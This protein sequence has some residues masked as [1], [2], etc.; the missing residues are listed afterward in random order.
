MHHVLS[1]S[2]PSERS[3]PMK[4]TQQLSRSMKWPLA[5]LGYFT[6]I[7]ATL[8]GS[9][10]AFPANFQQAEIKAAITKIKS[11]DYDIKAAKGSAG[12][13]ARPA[14][15]GRKKLTQSRLD[16]A[17]KKLA[18]AEKIMANIPADSSDLGDGRK[19]LAASKKAIAQIEAIINGGNS[20]SSTP[21]SGS[22][23]PATT[24]N[25]KQPTTTNKPVVKKLDYKQEKL[26]K[27]ARWY[28]LETEKYTKPASDVVKRMDAAGPKPLHKDV[29]AA[30]NSINTGIPK[31]NLAVG[32]I[33]KLPAAHPDVA[34]LR[35]KIQA[36][37]DLLGALQSRL[38][39]E[40]AKLQK[41]TGLEN[42]PNY[43][44]DYELVNGLARRYGNFSMSAEQPESFAQI[45]TEDGQSL[46]EF[47]RIAKIYQPLAEQKTDAGIKMEKRVIYAL[48][49]RKEFA[50]RLTEY[51]KKLPS[52]FAADI[53]EAEKLATQGVNEKKPMFFGENSG[54][55]QRF[56]WAEKKL[57]VIR[58]FGEKQAKPYVEQL[59]AARERIAKQAKSLEAEIIAN[60][61][62]PANR[63]TGPKRDALIKLAQETWNAEEK[64]AKYLAACIPSEA[65]NRD[66]R[67]RW[68][69]GSFYKIDSS[70]IQVQLIV[71]Y[72]DKL[73]VIRPV[74][75][76]KN[77]M[78]GDTITASPFHSKDEKL[79]PRNFIILDKV[80]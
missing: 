64:G 57:I 35:T 33:G 29:T 42:Y 10:K 16:S 56:G 8:L 24:G 30:L 39:V 4:N 38:K 28:L 69:S 25:P 53:A 72:N 20:G 52:S 40:S 66:T 15:G 11:A 67:W 1:A 43:Q 36:A 48:G 58:A 46:K 60:N 55:Q 3:S 7:A 41:I 32:Y 23:P 73:A 22:T 61:A 78:L 37:G 74:N 9:P 70:K 62:M 2:N 27:D 34:S 13:A 17:K 18:D 76:Y 6:I 80:K 51:K 65:W 59:E 68:S 71:K 19:Q 79:Q 63:F 45:I 14:K 31:F 26:L 49:K 54:I 75:I 21:A 77:H 44:K 5:C 12:T 50:N 47:R